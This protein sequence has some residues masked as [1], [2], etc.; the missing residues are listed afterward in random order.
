MPACGQAVGC[1]VCDTPELWR[2]AAG[3]CARVCACAGAAESL[4]TYIHTWMQA[5]THLCR[6]AVGPVCACMRVCWCRRIF[7]NIHTYMDASEDS[8]VP[9]G[10][11]P[12]GRSKMKSNPQQARLKPGAKRVRY[13]RMNMY[14]YSCNT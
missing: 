10:R 11:A 8:P 13:T 4:Q 9:R 14:V 3:L 5:K 6:E 7:T 12:R 2:G 1:G